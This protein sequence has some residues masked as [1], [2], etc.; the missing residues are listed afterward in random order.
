MK[1]LF[2]VL[3][4]A[5]VAIGV[6][7]PVPALAVPATLNANTVFLLDQSAVAVS[8]TG[9]TAEVTFATVNVPAGLV[10]PNGAIRIRAIFSH[11]SSAN[12]KLL[13]FRYGGSLVGWASITTSVASDLQVI[14]RSRGTLDSQ[15]TYTQPT[16]A[17]T[18]LT[19]TPTSVDGR[20]DQPISIICSL[21]VSTE[22]CSLEAYS[23]EVLRP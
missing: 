17:T 2:A 19:S 21:A 3:M 8:T 22:T 13:K 9:T 15:I 1:K 18:N 10:G 12:A 4:L 7:V 16:A 11:T 14:V 6:A 23:V 5:A 20:I